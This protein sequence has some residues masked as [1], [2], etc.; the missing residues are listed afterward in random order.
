MQRIPSRLE[1]TF[2]ADNEILVSL[3]DLAQVNTVPDPLSIATDAAANG[4]E[5]MS[6]DI[7]KK[8]ASLSS[9]KNVVRVG[10]AVPL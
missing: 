9:G 8:P 1:S 6:V 5:L 3:R 10:A 7:L 4:N 2:S